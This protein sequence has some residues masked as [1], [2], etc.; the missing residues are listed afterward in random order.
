[1]TDIQR[2]IDWAF[3]ELDIIEEMLRLSVTAKETHERG[4]CF[5]IPIFPLE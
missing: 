5:R 1:M 4:D 2:R 3:A